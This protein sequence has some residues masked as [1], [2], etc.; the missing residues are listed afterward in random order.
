MLGSRNFLQ[1]AGA[2]AIKKLQ[3]AVKPYLVGAEASKNPLKTAPR[4]QVFLEGIGAGAGPFFR[5]SQ[6]LGA[7]SK[8]KKVLAPQHWFLDK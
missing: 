5:G 4:S 3:G 8:L 2:R 1:G 6:E 7:G